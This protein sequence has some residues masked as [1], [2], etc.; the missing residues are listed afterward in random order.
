MIEQT[1]DVNVIAGGIIHL[2]S[3]TLIS[4]FMFVVFKVLKADQVHSLFQHMNLASFVGLTTIVY[5]LVCS[6]SM[7]FLIIPVG[8]AY[9]LGCSYLH[10]NAYNQ[11]IKPQL[12]E[13]IGMGLIIFFCYVCTGNN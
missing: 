13:L 12:L 9:I 11:A 6:T 5:S 4:F 3:M 2:L 7:N 10:V 1:S 8:I